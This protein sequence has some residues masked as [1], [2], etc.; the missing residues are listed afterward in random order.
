M[1]NNYRQN[2][3]IF[4]FFVTIRGKIISVS[5]YGHERLLIL[6]SGV[7]TT[8]SYYFFLKNF[9]DLGNS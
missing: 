7:E 5:L 9:G 2:L 1:E 4:P 6:S 8:K 3:T